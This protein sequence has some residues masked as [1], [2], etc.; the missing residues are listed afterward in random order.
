[1]ALQFEKYAQ[2][3]QYFINNLAERLGHPEEKGRTGIILRSVMHVMRDRLTIPESFHFM[4]QLPMA[5]KAVFVDNWKYRNEPLNIK[6]REE[7]ILEVENLQ[8]QY[9][10]REFN[11]N[12]STG[13]II[14]IVL[15]A[16]SEYVTRSE[17]DNVIEQMPMELKEMFYES[18]KH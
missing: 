16:L 5:L 8:S 17:F 9:G 1:M 12:K 6:T 3:G 13:E 14:Q 7:F 18:V 15:G 11:W 2:E 10:E 4:A